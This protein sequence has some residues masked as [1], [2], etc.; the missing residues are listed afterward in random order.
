MVEIAHPSP[1]ATTM[2]AA[3]PALP[4]GATDL[5]DGAV[6]HVLA[7]RAIVR[8]QVARSAIAS[9]GGMAVDAT[10]VP[11]APGHCAGDDPVILC[12]APDSWLLISERLDAA[13]LLEIVRRG[14]QG[15]TAAAV[16]VSDSLVSLHLAGPR[17]LMLLSRGTGL[18]V[19]GADFVP[20]R[21]VRTRFAQLPVILRPLARERIELL[22]DRG[23]AAWLH[24]WFVDAGGLL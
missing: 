9:A 1:A 19:H 14:S 20:G 3:A 21:C 24:E 10:S 12:V 6:L 11:T 4:I 15:R 5:A 22:V 17:A 18:D 8:L 2:L 23:P 13:D 7:S 16:D